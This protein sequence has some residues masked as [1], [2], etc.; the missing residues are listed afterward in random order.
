MSCFISPEI[1]Y[2][3]HFSS[4]SSIP[5]FVYT[6]NL[7]FTLFT[8]VISFLSESNGISCTRGIL[9]YILGSKLSLNAMSTNAVSVGSPVSF[10]SVLTFVSLHSIFAYISSVSSLSFNSNL[11]V[12]S[13]ISIPFSKS[14]ILYSFPLKNTFCTV[15]LFCVSVPVLSEH[16]TVLLPNVSTAGNF[17]TMA[18]F[19]TIFCTPIANTIVDT[20]TNPS[21]IAATANPTDV[22]NISIGSIFFIIPIKKISM[23][24]AK[25]AIPNI[26]PTCPNFFWIGV[27]GASFSII[28]F[29][30]FPTVVLIPVSVT[31]AF[32]CPFTTVLAINAMFFMSPNCSSLLHI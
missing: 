27:S 13:I 7:S 5:P 18:C 20:A 16:I 19:F 32:A 2:E 28:I 17:F 1:W 24:I 30:I 12:F 31:T 29:A 21:G 26:F 8:V 9:S 11:F 6:I 23:H 22:I 3:L 4:N 25:H 15:I 10:P 14:S